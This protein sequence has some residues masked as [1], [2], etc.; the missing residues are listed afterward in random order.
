M[1]GTGR[2]ADR[3]ARGG[4]RTGRRS[5]AAGSRFRGS[6]EEGGDGGDA[7]IGMR[8]AAAGA[9]RRAKQD[10]RLGAFNIENAPMCYIYILYLKHQFQY[11]ALGWFKLA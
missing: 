5:A 1:R 9:G 7:G 8:A 10:L 11:P 3:E 6:E 2:H 4:A